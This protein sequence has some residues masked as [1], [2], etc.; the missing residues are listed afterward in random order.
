MSS[1]DSK[2]QGSRGFVPVG[3]GCTPMFRCGDC[4][5]TSHSAGRRMRR[6]RGLRTWVCVH[7]AKKGMS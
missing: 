3:I 6:V 2:R 1:D 5:K 4:D 7:C